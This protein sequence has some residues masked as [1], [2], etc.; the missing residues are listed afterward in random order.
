MKQDGFGAAALQCTHLISGDKYSH[1]QFSP[2]ASH[3]CASKS[4]LLKSI[5]YQDKTMIHMIQS[6]DISFYGSETLTITSIKAR[7]GCKLH[8]FF[9]AVFI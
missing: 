2:S 5:F 4:L 9:N 1:T 7:P 8:I 6:G 3:C